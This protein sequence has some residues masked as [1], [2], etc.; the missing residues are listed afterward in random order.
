M[1]QPRL[2]DDIWLAPPVPDDTTLDTRQL[3]DDGGAG[4][5]ARLGSLGTDPDPSSSYR[6]S[7]SSPLLSCLAFP[8]LPAPRLSIPLT[9]TWA[10]L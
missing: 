1:N 3:W 2:S 4:G 7:S 5:A 9:L 10:T 8:L 6:Q